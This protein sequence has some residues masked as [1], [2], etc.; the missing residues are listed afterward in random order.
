MKIFNKIVLLVFLLLLSGCSFSDFISSSNN[1]NQVH[2]HIYEDGM[3]SCGQ[4]DP[5]SKKEF[6]H[7][8]SQNEVIEYYTDY[9]QLSERGKY[10]VDLIQNATIN[11]D[12]QKNA[13]YLYRQNKKETISR[14]E[15]LENAGIQFEE[16]TYSSF[17]GMMSTFI[18]NI[19]ILQQWA[20]STEKI[21][22]NNEY[23][24]REN[25]S[26][27]VYNVDKHN[28]IYYQLSFDNDGTVVA[29]DYL[30]LSYDLNK[31]KYY[32]ILIW[33]QKGGYFAINESNFDDYA[34]SCIN[35]DISYIDRFEYEEIYDEAGE[36]IDLSHYG[37]NAWIHEYLKCSK[38]YHATENGFYE[39]LINEIIQELE[40]GIKNYKQSKYTYEEIQELQKDLPQVNGAYYYVTN[41]YKDKIVNFVEVGERPS[42]SIDGMVENPYRV[43]LYSKNK[44]VY[45]NFTQL[46]PNFKTTMNSKEGINKLQVVLPNKESFEVDYITTNP[47]F[48]YYCETLYEYF[49][50]YGQDEKLDELLNNFLKSNN[51]IIE[52]KDTIKE[53]INTVEFKDFS[54]KRESILQE[55][56]DLISILSDNL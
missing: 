1:N 11:I 46:S 35:G 36:K 42:I 14:K 26:Y 13:N 24:L 21:V 17:D 50:L 10:A 2:K 47:Y 39:N 40:K 56:D 45:V 25:G 31:D 8:V 3:C 51:V 37:L 52:N 38:V 19:L 54:E 48:S 34:L 7:I 12:E 18:N 53:L 28:A 49:K 9:A 43:I 22:K 20:F 23:I 16:A 33:W 27:E 6:E 5:N 29:M 44:S 32:Y 15:E 4:S 41:G 55:F 30:K